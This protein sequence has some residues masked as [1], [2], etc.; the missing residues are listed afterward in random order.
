MPVPECIRWAAQQYIK[1]FFSLILSQGHLLSSFNTGPRWINFLLLSWAAKRRPVNS[2]ACTWGPNCGHVWLCVSICLAG[3]HIDGRA[4]Q[5]TVTASKRKKQESYVSWYMNTGLRR[6]HILL[7]GIME[8]ISLG[9][10]SH[11]VHCNKSSIIRCVCAT[12]YGLH[13]LCRMDLV[14]RRRRHIFNK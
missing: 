2:S 7:S 11:F 5:V 14:T 12:C 10:I 4:R 9:M 8:A 6:R 13:A 3:H 1:V